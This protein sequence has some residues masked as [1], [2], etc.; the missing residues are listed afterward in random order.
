MSVLPSTDLGAY[1][2]VNAAGAPLVSSAP[3]EITAAGT[4]DNTKVTGQSIDLLNKGDGG[5][6]IISGVATLQAA[7]TFKWAVEIQESADGTN[8][9]TAE[10]LQAATTLATG[11]EGGSTE[12]F[13]G[14]LDV[15]LKKR[16]RYVRFN[17]TPDLSA[18]GT[19]KQVS[20]WL[21]LSGGGNVIPA[22]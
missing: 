11:G 19:D 21:L 6:L 9:D 20:S 13:V 22:V 1:V 8:W 4:G 17:V 16:K 14:K 18:S 10:V 15:N 12:Y 2:A 5:C 7:E 3:S